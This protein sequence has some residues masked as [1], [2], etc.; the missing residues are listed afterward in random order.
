M[1]EIGE[2]PPTQLGSPRIKRIR[3]IKF[4]SAFYP[5]PIR[6]HYGYCENTDLSVYAGHF[7]GR[8]AQSSSVTEA[9]LVCAGKVILALSLKAVQ[10]FRIFV[11]T[12]CSW[13]LIQ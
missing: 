5:G 10:K 8:R 2:E 11:N 9:K 12:V 3:P 6:G 13:H 7:R 4:V 1:Y